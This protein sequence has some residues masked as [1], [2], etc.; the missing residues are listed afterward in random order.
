MIVSTF[1]CFFKDVR[2]GVNLVDRNYMDSLNCVE[3]IINRPVNYFN[4]KK[5]NKCLS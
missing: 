2:G 4:I 5:M 3:Q 1:V